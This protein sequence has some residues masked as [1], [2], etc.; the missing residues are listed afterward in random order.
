MAIFKFQTNT[1]FENDL[2]GK[3]GGSTPQNNTMGRYEVPIEKSKPYILIK[4]NLGVSSPME[5]APKK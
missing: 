1:N 5:L 4:G 2:P 3:V